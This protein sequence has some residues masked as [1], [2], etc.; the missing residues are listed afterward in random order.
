VLPL[1]VYAALPTALSTKLE[2]EARAFTVNDE[3]TEIVPPFDMELDE[4]VG[5]VPSVV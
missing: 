3:A 2:T 4:C 5:V 1:I